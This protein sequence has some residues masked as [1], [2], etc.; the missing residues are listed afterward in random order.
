MVDKLLYFRLNGYPLAVE[1]EQIERILINKHPSRDTFVLETGVE[2]KSLRSYIPLPEK[3]EITSSNIVFVKDQKDFYGFTVDRIIGY[4][5]LTGT[6]KL[7]TR[8]EKSP[9]KYFVRNEGRLIP[10]LDLQYITNNE[11]SV[12]VEDIEEIKNVSIGYD[13]RVSDEDV[14]EVFQEVSEE[15]IYRTIDDEILKRKR[16]QEWDNVIRSEKRGMV[17]PLIVNFVIIAFI[18][19]GFLYYFISN[20]VN[21]R[22]QMVGEK[23]SGVEE[24]L[25]REIRRRSE[26]EVEE[27]RKRLEDAR[28]RLEML[29]E[30]KDFFLQNQDRILMERERALSEQF[31]KQLE[32]ARK[33]FQASGVGNIDEAIAK[34]RDRLYDEYL[35]SRDDVRQEIDEI[36]QQYERELQTRESSIKQELDTYSKRINEVEQRL[37]EE[38]AKLKEAE[39]RAQNI[40]VQQQ[41]YI[42][43]R[44]QL[45]SVYNEALGH[46]QRKNYARGIERLNVLLP[47]IENARQKGI[48]DEMELK[49]EENLVSNILYLAERE[50]NR[51]DLDQVGRKTLEAAQALEREGKLKEALSRYFTVYTVSSSEGYKNT[52]IS[53]ADALM[54]RLY[55]DRTEMER[56]ELERKADQLFA[57][58]LSNKKTGNFEKALEDL[59]TIITDVSVKTRNKKTLDEIIAI[60]KLWALREEQKEKDSLNQKASLEFRDADRSYKDGYYTEA[61]SEYED[62]VMNY[63]DSDYADKAL[64]EIMRINKEMR[65]IKL[66]PP[67]SFKGGDT[68]SGVIIQA[69]S[70]GNVL[71]NLGSDSNVNE[72][73]VLQVYRKDNDQFTFIGSVKALDVFPRLTKGKVVYSEEVVKVGDLI[74]F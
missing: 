69:L 26:A 57:S 31:E 71:F 40:E 21:I 12:G 42:A 3:E 30:E 65:G 19:M 16:T 13:E 44:R 55:R 41:E 11:Q 48:G 9:I 27:Q 18:S 45:N 38:Q 72:G 59:E 51:I 64:S 33:R 46:L 60:N 37:V 54:D 47:I 49:V 24:E 23:I 50:Q 56:V 34:E 22:E 1:P 14:E 25:I 53:R 29:Q 6:E 66:T 62:I 10:V 17:L 28:K 68:D 74:A 61:L 35:N 39:Q 73:D 5:K 63:R 8:R 43:F 67:R 70:G 52:A 7:H 36:K 20:K 2:V 58:A 4:L 32:E 15:D